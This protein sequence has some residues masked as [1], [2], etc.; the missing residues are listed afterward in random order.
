MPTEKITILQVETKN[1]KAGAPMWTATTSIGKISTFDSVLGAKLF[2]SIGKILNVEYEVQGIY[3]N[4]K[5]IVE[6]G[7]QATALPLSTAAQI[8]DTKNRTSSASMMIA[9]AKDLVVAGKVEYKDLKATAKELLTL[10]EE[11]LEGK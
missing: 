10:Y 2:A 1:T 7:T 4:L 6:D 9:Y 11:M 5:A 3:K 8:P